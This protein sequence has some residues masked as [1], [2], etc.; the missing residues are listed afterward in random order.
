MIFIYAAEYQGSGNFYFNGALVRVNDD[1]SWDE[2]SSDDRRPADYYGIFKPT[3]YATDGPI[4]HGEEKYDYVMYTSYDADGV[5]VL[6]RE[7]LESLTWLGSYGSPEQY[8][9]YRFVSEVTY[10]GNDIWFTIKDGDYDEEKAIGWRDAYAINH[11][12]VYR[13]DGKTGEI[14]L[15]YKY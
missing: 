13:K 5:D 10:S 4:W 9:S 2:I 12:Y 3:Y 15:V 1:G 8:Y 14:K 6:L 7:E 11:T